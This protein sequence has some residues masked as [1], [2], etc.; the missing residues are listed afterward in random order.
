MA[1]WSLAKNYF[2]LVFMTTSVLLLSFYSLEQSSYALEPNP[3]CS[4]GVI[5]GNDDL[6]TFTIKLSC[7]NLTK[8]VNSGNVEANSADL[9]Q[10]IYQP[11]GSR[12]APKSA[13]INGNELWLVFYIEYGSMDRD[14]S[15]SAGLLLNSSN[16][17]NNQILISSANILDHDNPVVE[18]DYYLVSTGYVFNVSAADGV[19][20]NDFD[21]ESAVGDVELITGPSFGDLI[22]NHDGSFA[23]TPLADY[24][25]TDSFMYQAKDGSGNSNIATVTLKD[26]AP[27]VSVKLYNKSAVGSNYAKVG[28]II[29]ADFEVNEPVDVN[30]SKI[31]KHDT[32]PQ[33]ID[34]NHYCIEYTMQELDS[35]G[36]ISY[37]VEVVDS[38]GNLGS[39][40]SESDVVFDKTAPVI[41]LTTGPKQDI[42]LYDSS[43]VEEAVAMDN[44]TDPVNL[45]VSGYCDFNKVGSYTLT[46]NATDMAG[47]K[48]ATVTRTMDVID[49]IAVYYDEVSEELVSLGLS[50]NLNIANTDNYQHLMGLYVEKSVNDV[51]IGR[52]TFNTPVDLSG[53]MEGFLYELVDRMEAMTVGSIGIDLTDAIDSID[54]NHLSA[55]IKFYN[56]DK[57]GYINDSTSEDVY[58]AIAAFDD[59][60]NPMNKSALDH[61]SATYVGCE[62]GQ[63]EH[64][65]FEIKVAHF[66]RYEIGKNTVVKSK[67]SSINSVIAHNNLSNVAMIAPKVGPGVLNRAISGGTSYSDSFDEHVVLGDNSVAQ[68]Q[69]TIKVNKNKDD[70]VAQKRS[71][72]I[73]FWL[74]GGVISIVFMI[75]IAF[76]LLNRIEL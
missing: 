4:S 52:I 75:I 56:L 32:E 12:Y 72:D 50:N 48:A 64:Y 21:A 11:N 40:N 49:Q 36:L 31:A 76:Y 60:G 43:Y 37:A 10:I 71:Y 45:V 66:S 69:K 20:H 46:Y 13:I 18:P 30:I 57:L 9:V 58:L 39:S 38:V 15:L 33:K 8:F 2:L 16:D 47:N 42:D 5:E 7:A 74:L 1:G 23:Y 59:S 70:D 14:V 55:T 53:D 61:Q 3:I 27:K 44:Y 51:K 54:Y 19:L 63:G 24:A 29:R 67:I 6:N 25:G 22:L 62:S 34:D 28:D 65:T 35:E 68:T 26:E 41:D 17:T 73:Q